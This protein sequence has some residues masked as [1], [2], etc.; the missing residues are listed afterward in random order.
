MKHILLVI[1]I[2]TLVASSAIGFAETTNRCFVGTAFDTKKKAISYYEYYQE[3]RID[4]K[5]NVATV[6]YV[7]AESR[8]F[9]VKQLDFSNARFTPQF[10]LIDQRIDYQEGAKLEDNQVLI[11]KKSQSDAS[12]IQTTIDKT[13]KLVID[14]GF[15]QFVQHHFSVL[16][17][18]E[19][20]TFYFVSPE[21]LDKFKFIM[22]KSAE[23]DNT[24]T[25]KMQLSNPIYRLLTDPIFL[26]YEKSTKYLLEYR[27][28][29]NIKDPQGENYTVNIR[30]D[31]SVCK[32][33]A[34]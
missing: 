31:Y 23:T 8:P 9:A 29:S 7:D 32:T 11:Y 16:S 1:I 10:A 6:S 27:G 17:Q 24:I 19:T 14:A 3:T 18:G 25:L 30:Y 34:P 12:L 21:K 13:D 28:L 20:I 22:Q 5:V 15:D 26:I 2:P 4:N 33:P